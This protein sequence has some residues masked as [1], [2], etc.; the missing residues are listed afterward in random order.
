M[1]M[2][3]ATANGSFAYSPISK[4]IVKQ[5]MTVAVSTPLKAIPVFP[6]AEIICGLTM[7]MYAIVKKVV[8]PAMASV[9]T[10]GFS[11]AEEFITTED[12]EKTDIRNWTL[13]HYPLILVCDPCGEFLLDQRLFGLL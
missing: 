10:D 5:I 4:V 3:G 6:S 11:A 13:S 8:M 12:T 1:P 7:T 9:L 2:P